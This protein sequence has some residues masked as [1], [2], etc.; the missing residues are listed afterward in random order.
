MIRE[1]TSKKKDLLRLGGVDFFA[2]TETYDDTL[3][4]LITEYDL[5]TS[6]YACGCDLKMIAY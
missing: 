5:S 4:T 3:G 2:T 6:E 1:V